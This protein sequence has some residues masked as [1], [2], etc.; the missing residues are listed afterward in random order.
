MTDIVERLRNAVTSPLCREAAAEIERLNTLVDRLQQLTID[1]GYEIERLRRDL[2]DMEEEHESNNL[3]R[4]EIE[5]LRDG[6]AEQ[7]C[8]IEAQHQKGLAD[9]AE[10]E[11]LQIALQRLVISGQKAHDIGFRKTD[12]WDEFGRDLD[13]AKSGTRINE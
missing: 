4:R 12:I 6:M 13:F 8:H 9:E 10:I 3:Q 1:K 5:R 11:R 2:D 7:E